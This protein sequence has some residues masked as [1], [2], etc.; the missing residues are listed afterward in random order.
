MK[1]LLAATS[2]FL[3]SL[4][5]CSRLG[6]VKSYQA[7]GSSPAI[8]RTAFNGDADK[9]RVL[10]LVSP[11]CGMCLR[12]ASEVSQQLAKAANGKDT[13]SM[14][15]GFQDSAR[16]KRSNS[17][18]AARCGSVSCPPI[19]TF[20]RARYDF[21]FSERMSSCAPGST[22]ISLIRTFLIMDPEL[23]LLRVMDMKGVIENQS[24]G[25]PVFTRMVAIFASLALLLAAIG[26]YGLI[27]YSVG[28]R[29]HEIGI[30]LALGVNRS[31][32]FWMILKE[33]LRVTGIG[34]L[35]GLAIAVPLPGLFDSMFF[36][37]HFGA[38]I[39]YPITL[40]VVL[41]MAIFAT[42]VPARRATHIDPMVALRD[43]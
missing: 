17:A 16:G 33:G 10:M 43:E 22:F 9:V 34:S 36:G 40:A 6:S 31:D 25:D 39:L 7:L 41:M 15:F 2:F 13:A 24:N 37:I 18:N 26:I 5:A 42:L 30:R 38:P 14:S 12:G 28:Q 32:I 4:S 20:S 21:I 1:S 23:P 19:R 8:V 27:A 11:T 3:L 29:S 35:V